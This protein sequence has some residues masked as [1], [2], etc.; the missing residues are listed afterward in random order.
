MLPMVGK[1]LLQWFVLG[2]LG[3]HFHPNPPSLAQ[4]RE[5]VKTRGRRGVPGL[6]SCPF[7]D[8]VLPC[9][10]CLLKVTFLSARL[11][12]WE[13][14]VILLAQQNKLDGKCIVPAL[15][16]QLPPRQHHPSRDRSPH[17]KGLEKVQL[18]FTHGEQQPPPVRQMYVSSTFYF[19]RG[20]GQGWCP[21]PNSLL[22]NFFVGLRHWGHCGASDD[23]SLIL[24]LGISLMN[25][26]L[27]P[28]PVVTAA[29]Q[30]L[31][32]LSL[33]TGLAHLWVPSCQTP[34]DGNCLAV[35]WPTALIS[36]EYPFTVT[37]FFFVHCAQRQRWH[38]S[39]SPA[40]S[41]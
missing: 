18:W 25:N 5:W 29:L 38:C 40:L 20:R 26:S 21:F 39:S 11:S 14:V 36:F 2:Q 8:R 24:H 15:H 12:F 37:A 32:F 7:P 35:L 10:S 19:L 31:G 33:W 23:W 6:G 3:A 13:K 27:V 22:L 9:N 4:G 41:F 30:G 34:C 16:V 1:S 28:A 17:F